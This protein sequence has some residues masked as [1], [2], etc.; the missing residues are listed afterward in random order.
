MQIQKILNGKMNSD[1]SEFS[2]PA[3]DYQ[4]AM[5]IRFVG[6]DGG[7]IGVLTN[8]KS[9]EEIPI[10]EDL[11]YLFSTSG[12]VKVEDI[13]VTVAEDVKK[14]YWFTYRSDN[15][16]FILEFDL[17]SKIITK[18]LVNLEDTNN[19][20]ITR[21][22]LK[23][24]ILSSN[25]IDGKLLTWTDIN[26]GPK[27]LNVIKA[28][29]G[30]Y[31]NFITD[32][33]ISAIKA[34]PL[35]PATIEF[36]S[37]PDKNINLLKKNL[38]QFSSLW[39]YDDNERSVYSPESVR[40]TPTDEPTPEINLDPTKNNA[41]KVTFDCGPDE[42][43]EIELAARSGI[44]DTFLIG[45]FNR[46]E[47]TT[48]DGSGLPVD[49]NYDVLNNLYTFYFYNDG[50]YNNV[51]I[52]EKALYFDNVPRLSKTQE[53]ANNV[54]LY[55]N[56]KE[57]YNPVPVSGFVNVTYNKEET[58]TFFGKSFK[59]W[60]TNS[61][62]QFGLVYFDTYG[63]SG[64]V[65]TIDSFKVITKPFGYAHQ[66]FA[67]KMIWSISSNPPTWAYRYQWVRTNNLTHQNFLFW[68]VRQ[69]T[70]VTQGDD[71]YYDLFI[72]TL[73]SYNRVNKSSIIS[74][75]YTPGD[76][77][78]LHRSDPTNYQTNFDYDIVEFAVFTPA[79]GTDPALPLY[80]LRVRSLPTGPVISAG[81]LI[82]IYTPKKSS[83]T[84]EDLNVFYEFGE[85]Y[86]IINP[87]T[88]LATH[89]KTTGEFNE[90]DVFYRT[91]DI[92]IQSPSDD[93]T[94]TYTF[95]TEEIEDPN[96]SDSYI[97]NYS[98]NGRANLVDKNYKENTFT[99]TIR[100]SQVYKPDTNING[101][102]RFYQ[103]SFEDYDKSMGQIQLI[104][105]RDNYLV[106]FQALKTGVVP[107]NLTIVE[108]Q[109]GSNLALISQKFLNNIRYYFG[110]FGVGD[111]PEAIVKDGGYYYFPDA[112]RGVYCRLAGDGINAISKEAYMD[113]FFI[114]KLSDYAVGNQKINSGFDKK[115]KECVISFQN[116]DIDIFD[117]ETSSWTTEDQLYVKPNTAV[118]TVEPTHG[119]IVDNPSGIDL[120]S[121]NTNYVGPD[122]VSFT[123][124]NNK[125][126]ILPEKN[127]CLNV[128][129][130][131]RPYAWV[132]Y[133]PKCFLSGDDNLKYW[134]NRRLQ[135]TDGAMEPV[136]L[137][138]N[139]LT[140]VNYDPLDPSGSESNPHYVP[141]VADVTFCVSENSTIYVSNSCNGI[142]RVSYELE[143]DPTTT[144]GS[145]EVNPGTSNSRTVPTGVY[146]I[147]LQTNHT[148]TT[149][150]IAMNV[151]AQFRVGLSGSA[152]AFLHVPTS[153]NVSVRPTTQETT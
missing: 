129:D 65:N 125:G 52:V 120:Y 22:S 148:P 112:S 39:V 119:T 70:L 134:L 88:T 151:G 67:P 149:L 35:K 104:S 106:V 114:N 79:T 76:R 10:P 102:N 57:G 23:N 130:L 103:L 11:Q 62:Y 9:N 15:K 128:I 85:A 21:F 40:A 37:D 143:S 41:I 3:G 100:F 118:V 132:G 66:C 99:S 74:Y 64:T 26:T 43:K 38:F 126:D 17:R 28:K 81:A 98:S 80:R 44:G 20:D 36:Y 117:A 110:D 6:S 83:P 29:S 18:V 82:E 138:G 55:A 142:C 137:N 141:P 8:V 105:L 146:K 101:L 95:E 30:M 75:D 51:D 124:Q 86:D 116:E 58:C 152:Y 14:M 153:I 7:N 1:V 49:S 136:V 48:L 69:A 90:G 25:L 47:I 115:N 61:A 150:H 63:R 59:A 77:I 140:E 78:T 91:R 42:V 107:V 56:N 127:V 53:Y 31:G 139:T 121:P 45:V 27:K 87:G 71:K 4:Y 135:F 113:N 108:D 16:D 54:M 19:I 147:T 72:D 111:H 5:N 50:L 32:Q 94:F 145:Y 109:N 60:K 144:N 96:F 93:P 46:S 2:L 13:H 12:G 24:R 131:G 97:S 133:N 122:K 73:E 89:S 92:P 84:G 33:N 123:F 34:P 68:R